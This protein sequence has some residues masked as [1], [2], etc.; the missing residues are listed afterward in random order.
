MTKQPTNILAILDHYEARLKAV[1]AE[2]KELDALEEQANRLP[3]AVRRVKH[4]EKQLDRLASQN[5][6]LVDRLRVIG[7]MAGNVLYNGR[8]RRIDHDDHL[9]SW[10]Q[11]EACALSQH[12]GG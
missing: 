6:K 1:E 3:G 2:L 11:I 12:E 4:L 10:E 7:T 8:Q 5:A 9:R